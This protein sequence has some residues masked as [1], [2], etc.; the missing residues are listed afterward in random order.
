MLSAVLVVDD[1][2][3]FLVLAARVLGEMGVQVVLT[4]NDAA[5][6][7]GEVNAKRP[8]AAL[9]DVGLPDRDGI[10]LARELTELPWGPQIVLTSTD[11]DAGRVID[12]LDG[13][14]P[15]IPKEEL[16]S[17]TLRQLLTGE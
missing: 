6:A 17:G 10:D 1:D 16:A 8:D 11:P 14:I 5:G 4:A 7:V 12:L 13:T 15:F 2:P 9:V 3:D